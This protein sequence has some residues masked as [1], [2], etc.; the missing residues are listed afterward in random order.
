MYKEPQRMIFVFDVGGGG[1]RRSLTE[2]APRRDFSFRPKNLSKLK[3]LVAIVQEIN[4]RLSKVET[5]IERME[6]KLD[7]RGWR[8]SGRLWRLPREGRRRADSGNL[9]SASSAVHI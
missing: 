8:R 6:K 4:Y 1:W 3:H 5:L 9:S 2:E 7:G